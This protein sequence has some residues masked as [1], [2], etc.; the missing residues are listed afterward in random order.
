M[1]V[2]SAPAGTPGVVVQNGQTLKAEVDHSIAVAQTSTTATA[3]GAVS[4]V[5]GKSKTSGT[6]GAAALTGGAGDTT[7]TGGAAAVTGG[8][9]GSTSG[10]G[11][12]ASLTG[13]A[14][15]A[16]NANGGDVTINGGA[17]NGSGT[18]GKVTVQSAVAAPAGGS[19]TACLLLGSTAGFGIYFGSGAPSVSA[20]KGS[21]YLRND[22]STTND[23]I[24]VNTSG[25]TTWA[26][27]TSAS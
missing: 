20:A 11:G 6:G 8:A 1:R 25:S 21:L 18:R 23:R 19:A 22:G 9:G 12:A 26:A 17:P 2:R 4:V 14:G 13:G 16:G 7:G 24:Y 5:A 27:L 15:S 3:G 10:T